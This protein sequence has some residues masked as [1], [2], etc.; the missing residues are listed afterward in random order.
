MNKPYVK[1][2][3]EDGEVTNP[4]TKKSPYLHQFNTTSFNKKLTRGKY[5]ILKNPITGEFIGFGSKAGGNN[6][7]NTCKRGKN[8]RNERV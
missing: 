7:A 2:Y 3:N 6:R 4:I 1:Q 8:S 5:I